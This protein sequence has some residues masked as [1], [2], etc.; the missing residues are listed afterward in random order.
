MVGGADGIRRHL[1][2]SVAFG[3]AFYETLIVALPRVR[4]GGGVEKDDPLPRV[5][6]GVERFLELRGAP[7]LVI[8]GEYEDVGL[9][10]ESQG[11]FKIQG[12][13]DIGVRNGG[14]DFAI[15]LD[16]IPWEMV[17]GTGSGD[18]DAEGAFLFRLSEFLA[19][20]GRWI[21]EVDPESSRVRLCRWRPCRR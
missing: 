21:W 18:E 3:F 9:R 11:F 2:F 19:E 15:G 16:E 5:R 6:E 7:L 10:E 13:G 12:G 8:P 17:G 14:E 20:G 4:P 1:A